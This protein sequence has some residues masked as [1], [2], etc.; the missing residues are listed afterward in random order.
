MLGY[1]SALPPPL[2]KLA[3][4]IR[5]AILCYPN[6]RTLT[7]A[8]TTFHPNLFGPILPQLIGCP[9]LCELTVNSSCTGEENIQ[10][11]VALEQL[12]KLTIIDPTRAILIHLPGWLSNLPS[13]L[14]LRLRVR[15]INSFP[16]GT[17]SDNV[18]LARPIVAPCQMVYL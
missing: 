4:R 11:L 10:S 17:D 8:P 1:I 5:E 14:E 12:T 2:N 3:V 6:L 9:N 18:L 13:L 15:A 7:L 16:S